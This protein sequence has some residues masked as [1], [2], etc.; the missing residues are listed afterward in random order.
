MVDRHYS[1]NLIKN[2]GQ[3]EHYMIYCVLVDQLYVLCTDL[4][5]NTLLVCRKFLP[6]GCAPRKKIIFSCPT[7]PENIFLFLAAAKSKNKIFLCKQI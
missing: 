7:G 5:K 4:A 1:L 3:L 2:H 6:P